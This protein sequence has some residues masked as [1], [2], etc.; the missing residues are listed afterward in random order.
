MKAGTKSPG[1]SRL[2]DEAQTVNEWGAAHK[3][4]T[5]SIGNR[6]T[7][8]TTSVAWTDCVNPH[9]AERP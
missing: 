9:W 3:K 6:C 5:P 7:E 1:R 8:R 4:M 2:S